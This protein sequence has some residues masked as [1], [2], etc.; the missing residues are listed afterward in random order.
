M[1]LLVYEL[2]KRKRLTNVSHVVCVIREEEKKVKNFMKSRKS[3]LGSKIDIFF[4]LHTRNKHSLSL[5]KYIHA[6]NA[7]HRRRTHFSC[8]CVCVSLSRIDRR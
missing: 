7:S 5:L 8:V 4:T 6:R 2:E 1:V 3:V